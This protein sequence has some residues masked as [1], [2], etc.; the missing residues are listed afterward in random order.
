MEQ[1]RVGVLRS[2][3]LLPLLHPQELSLSDP[4]NNARSELQLEQ[5]LGGDVLTQQETEL[6][7]TVIPSPVLN[8]SGMALLVG[9]LWHSV[10]L[11]GPS[12]PR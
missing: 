7:S 1:R 12:L 5:Q 4:G 3:P 6:P 10:C 8:P 9:S 11:A 2:L